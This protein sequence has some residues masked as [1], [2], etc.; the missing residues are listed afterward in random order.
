M[1]LCYMLVLRSSVVSFTIM[2]VICVAFSF[3][4]FFYLSAR[5]MISMSY[6]VSGFDFLQLWFDRLVLLFRIPYSVPRGNS[7]S[8]REILSP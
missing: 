7:S 8:I 2:V 4:F 1:R 3:L 5:E 6:R